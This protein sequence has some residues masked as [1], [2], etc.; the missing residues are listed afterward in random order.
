MPTSPKAFVG[1]IADLMRKASPSKK[2][3]LMKAGLLTNSSTSF[4]RR[5]TVAVKR[6]FADLRQAGK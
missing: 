3:A 5:M 2:S 6:L 1:T 4:D